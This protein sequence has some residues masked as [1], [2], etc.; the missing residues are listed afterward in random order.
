[1]K[2][3]FTLLSTL[4]IAV[5]IVRTASAWDQPVTLK[6]F[7]YEPCTVTLTGKVILVSVAANAKYDY[8][9]LVLSKPFNVKGNPHSD[10]DSDSFTNIKRIQISSP[11]G[12]PIQPYV[13]KT[14]AIEGN[15]F[16]A[17]TVH[18]FTKV[19]IW[20]KTIKVLSADKHH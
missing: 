5:A 8:Y 2:Y 10:V 1:M 18:H 17:N 16:E 14:I 9:A 19:L 7:C 12:V 15:L 4:I 20:A 11:F 6:T 13:G 3:I